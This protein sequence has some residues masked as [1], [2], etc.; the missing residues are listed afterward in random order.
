MPRLPRLSVRLYPQHVVQRGNNR[1]PCFLDEED[2]RH[3]LACLGKASTKYAV[4]IH[5]YVLMGNHVHLLLTPKTDTG[6]SLFMQSVGRRYVWYFNRRHNRTGTLWE[7]RYRASLV[8]DD[9]YL[10]A[11]YRYIE[12][13]PVRAGLAGDPVGYRWSSYS[14]NALGRRNPLVTPHA[15]F[16][17]L[18]RT[19]SETQA[20]YRHLIGRFIETELL[21]SIR[22]SLQSNR[23]FGSFDFQRDMERK[24][25]FRIAKRKPGP[26]KAESST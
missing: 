11:C 9:A 12:L 23:I 15:K 6:V 5:A 16:A 1:Q 22:E 2:Y 14:A 19:P 21:E 7:G 17:E 4:S 26:P 13:N 8:Q 24:L 25:A 20:A 18:G 10:L 3:Y